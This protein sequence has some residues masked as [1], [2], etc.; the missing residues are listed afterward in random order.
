MIVKTTMTTPHVLKQYRDA[1]GEQPGFD[2]FCNQTNRW[3]SGPH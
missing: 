2:L 3:L 1:G